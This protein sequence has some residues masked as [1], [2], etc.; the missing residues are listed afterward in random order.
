MLGEREPDDFQALATLAAAMAEGGAVGGVRLL[1]PAATA[2][3]QADCVTDSMGMG[4]RRMTDG[5]FRPENRFTYAGW[6]EFTEQQGSG[7][8]GCSGWLGIGG[9]VLQCTPPPPAATASSGYS[10]EDRLWILRQ[11]HACIWCRPTSER[12]G[13]STR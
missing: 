13:C 3:A 1:S 2:R 9:S 10:G 4:G 5:D 12:R 7:C 8:D 11:P 6:N